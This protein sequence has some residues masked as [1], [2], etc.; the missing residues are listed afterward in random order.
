MTLPIVLFGITA[1]GGAFLGILRFQGKP[2]PM[3]VSVIH[4][5]VAAAGLVTLTIAVVGNEVHSLVRYSLILFL[6]A[7]LGGFVAFSFHLRKKE[8]P[9]PLMLIHA[10]AAVV[11][12][13]DVVNGWIGIGAGSGMVVRC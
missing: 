4:G 9:I 7:A 11:A 13:C 8:L 3:A 10:A 5:L 1:L 2:F 6:V 12:Y